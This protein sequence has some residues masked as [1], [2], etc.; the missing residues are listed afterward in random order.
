VFVHLVIKNPLNVPLNLSNL[1]IRCSFGDSSGSTDTDRSNQILVESSEFTIENIPD[2]SMDANQTTRIQINIIPKLEG[3]IHILGVVYFIGGLIPSFKSLGKMVDGVLK[4][5]MLNVT[6]PMPVLD[7]AFDD[8]PESIVSGEVRTCVLRIKNNGNRGLMNLRLK[9]SH[10]S[11]FYAG[12]G[13]D[14]PVYGMFALVNGRICRGW[15]RASGRVYDCQ[16][17]G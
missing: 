17:N 9:V 10:P 2:F 8:F 16:F 4:A 6:L 13:S 7:V 11:F 5:P 15:R 12:T 3:A 14:Q 1:S